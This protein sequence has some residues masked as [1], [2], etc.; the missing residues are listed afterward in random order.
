V[1]Q[2]QR[3][4]SE[5]QLVRHFGARVERFSAAPSQERFA[6]ASG[7]FCIL[8]EPGPQG[9]R[10]GLCPPEGGSGQEQPWFP[11]CETSLEASITAPG[12]SFAPEVVF[13][14]EA[15]EWEVRLRP[16]QE[17]IF[18]GARIRANLSLTYEGH[19]LKGT[20]LELTLGG[21]RQISSLPHLWPT[22]LRLCSSGEEL[23][24]AVLEGGVWRNETSE[25]VPHRCRIKS[26]T[27]ESAC[28]LVTGLGLEGVTFAGDST[29]R[30]MFN[31]FASFFS[32]QVKGDEETFDLLVEGISEEL[33]DKCRGK[34]LYKNEHICHNSFKASHTFCGGRFNVTLQQEWLISML[35]LGSV[36][37]EG[38]NQLIVHN[39]GMHDF[40]SSKTLEDL[41]QL[42]NALIPKIRGPLEELR[43][44]G[45]YR[46]LWRRTVRMARGYSTCTWTDDRFKQEK[47]DAWNS[48]MDLEM[49][50]MGVSTLDLQ[51][52]IRA[53]YKKKVD[54]VH[55]GMEFNL[56]TSHLLLHY[57]ELTW[58]SEKR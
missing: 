19:D 30:H 46:Y 15:W 38:R 18:R 3:F 11:R 9:V 41:L 23:L 51:E 54:P 26:Y 5:E 7:L 44:R 48:I 40:M 56:M 43:K 36:G 31:G 25:F 13:S 42:R 47:I 58:G 39:I 55:L 20:P 8:G 53:D 50:R 6:E 24:E 21:S 27:P 37:Q 16:E 4:F 52:M 57:L 12:I 29:S 32:G 2:S 28:V 35:N 34:N 17:A 45:D 1:G 22:A 14:R 33:K 10:V 49:R